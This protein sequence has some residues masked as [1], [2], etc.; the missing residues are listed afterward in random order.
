MSAAAKPVR[1]MSDLQARRRLAR[2]RRRLLRVDIGLGLL[3][4]ILGLLLASGLAIVAVAALVVLAVC[5]VSILFER[6]RAR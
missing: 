4:A 1:D 5:I 6:W 3:V 2:R